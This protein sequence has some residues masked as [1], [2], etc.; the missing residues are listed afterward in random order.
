MPQLVNELND[1]R[2]KMNGVISCKGN[3]VIKRLWKLDTD[4]YAADALGVTTKELLVPVASMVL[5]CDDCNKYILGKAHEAGVTPERL[6]EVFA[7]T[8][9]VAGIIVVPHARRAA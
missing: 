2:T 9:I 4:T 6:F 3:L 5:R 8:K 7:V 1:N